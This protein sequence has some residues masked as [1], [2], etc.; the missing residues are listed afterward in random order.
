MQPTFQVPWERLWAAHVDLLEVIAAEASDIRPILF[1]C[2]GKFAVT[3]AAACLAND[4]KAKHFG[5][6]H[7]IDDGLDQTCR[8]VLK[9]L[10]AIIRSREIQLETREFEACHQAE[11]YK[12]ISAF[13]RMAKRRLPPSACSWLTRNPT[14]ADWV[15]V[16]FGMGAISLIEESEFIISLLRNRFEFLDCFPSDVTPQTVAIIERFAWNSAWVLPEI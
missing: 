2:G 16:S 6:S 9:C 7:F 3:Y 4:V 11:W 5:P 10:M 8:A 13:F 1:L 15:R 12:L 14:E